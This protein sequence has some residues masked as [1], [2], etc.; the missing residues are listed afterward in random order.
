MPL[1]GL[2][3]LRKKMRRYY[4]SYVVFKVL[5]ISYHVN[6]YTLPATLASLPGSALFHPPHRKWYTRRKENSTYSMHNTLPSTTLYKPSFACTHPLAH[7]LSSLI[8]SRALKLRLQIVSMLRRFHL[9]Q[10][11]AYCLF[12]RNS[13]I[14]TKNSENMLLKLEMNEKIF[15]LPFDAFIFDKKIMNA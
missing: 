14:A 6:P 3:V 1:K 5:F 2:G 12:H 15:K 4:I 7:V 11:R 8:Y 9:S 13:S 10:F